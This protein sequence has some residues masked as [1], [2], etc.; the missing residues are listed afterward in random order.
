MSTLDSAISPENVRSYD[1]AGNKLLAFAKTVNDEDSL[2]V[3][4][5]SA[6]R[7]VVVPMG[8][9]GEFHAFPVE[10]GR[11][12]IEYAAHLFPARSLTKHEVHN[13]ADIVLNNYD[14]VFNHRPEQELS[15]EQL[16]ERDGLIVKV[17]GET[18][19]DATT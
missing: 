8:R 10:I 15:L 11:A 19:I 4:N 14:L 9:F 6:K 5:L 17:D 3:R 1:L 2:I 12:A 16:M 13:L 18:I 7:S